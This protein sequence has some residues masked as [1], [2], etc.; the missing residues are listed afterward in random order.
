MIIPDRLNVFSF[1]TRY[2]APLLT[3]QGWSHLSSAHGQGGQSILEALLKAQ[4]L[5]DAE[6][7]RGMETQA[8]LVRTYGAAEL[9]TE[10]TVHMLV[11]LVI[12]P[13]HPERQWQHLRF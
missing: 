12:Q 10:A 4:E 6:V 8:T 5:H 1:Y 7:D 9:H 3:A 2:H 13:W 11:A